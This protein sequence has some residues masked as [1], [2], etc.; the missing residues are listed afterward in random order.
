MVEYDPFVV[1]LDELLDV[2]WKTHDPTQV[3]STYLFYSSSNA[4]RML[5]PRSA[6]PSRL[7]SDDR[8]C[9]ARVEGAEFCVADDEAYLGVTPGSA[10]E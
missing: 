7:T 5:P 9:L 10:F 6:N 2:F 4:T 1:T 8:V 3:T